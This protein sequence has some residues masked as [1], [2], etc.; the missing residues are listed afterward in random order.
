M[1][2]GLTDAASL[3][4]ACL[5]GRGEAF[6]LARA[7]ADGQLRLEQPV[8]DGHGLVFG[9]GPFAERRG[10]QPDRLGDRV[11]TVQQ[12]NQ[13]EFVAADAEELAANGILDHVT[14]LLIELGG[15]ETK[16]GAERQHRA[17]RIE[18]AEVEFGVHVRFVP[19]LTLPFRRTD[20]QIRPVLARTDLEIRPTVSHIPSHFKPV[21]HALCSRIHSSVCEE[22]VMVAAPFMPGRRTSPP[23]SR[24]ISAMKT[25]F[26]SRI[27]ERG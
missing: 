4:W 15:R 1:A 22:V 8:A 16:I 5:R 12:R 9:E 19:E 24:R 11:L 23:W 6:G 3:F 17:G 18:H 13:G 7:A 25:L 27:S 21:Y 20:F 14:R 2:R 10:R 26:E